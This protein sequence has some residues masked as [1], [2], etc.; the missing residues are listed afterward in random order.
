MASKRPLYTNAA[1]ARFRAII[2]PSLIQNGGVGATEPRIAARAA[3]ALQDWL[4]DVVAETV[5]ASRLRDPD[6]NVYNQLMQ[7]VKITGRSSLST[8]V[9]RVDAYPWLF[10]HEFGAH[11]VPKGHKYLAI[12]LFHAM[13]PDGSLKY[14]NPS[15]WG[16]WGAFVYKQKR[17]GKLFLAYKGADGELRVLYILLPFVNIKA[18]LGLNVTAKKALGA[19]LSVWG[20]I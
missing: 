20:V 15:S 11:I 10:P 5:Q 16:R 6:R 8:L 12:P 13:R 2:K 9:G 18:T 1:A 19:L 7:G 17:T 14:N 4:M 3:V